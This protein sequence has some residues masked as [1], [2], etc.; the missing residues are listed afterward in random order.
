LI[1]DILAIIHGTF[2]RQV[3]GNCLSGN[4]LED[5]PMQD[6]STVASKMKNAEKGRKKEWESTQN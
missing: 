5:V 6:T 3:R 4:I 2:F 1:R